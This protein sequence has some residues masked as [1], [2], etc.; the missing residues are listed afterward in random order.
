MFAMFIIFSGLWAAIPKLTPEVKL[1]QYLGTEVRIGG[2]ADRELAL[3]NVQWMRANNKPVERIVI[4]LGEQ[5][6]TKLKGNMGYFHVAMKEQPVPRLSVDLS[7]IQKTR[8][9][10]NTVRK[11][12]A[13]SQL[14]SK[15]D[16]TMDPEDGSTNLTFVLKKTIKW[17]SFV[18]KD[19][20]QLVLDLSEQE[21]VQKP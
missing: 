12:L 13:K 16:F 15:V 7:Q 8:I 9:D 1:N 17:D 18:Q 6:G 11:T 2:V 10:E 21:A 19:K 14:I 4:Q 5:D 20:G 3:L